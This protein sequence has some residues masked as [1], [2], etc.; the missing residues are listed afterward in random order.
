MGLS[1]AFQAPEAFL[2]QQAGEARQS[3]RTW[4]K[5]SQES[6][7]CR[8]SGLGEAGAGWPSPALVLLGCQD[9]S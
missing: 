1:T 3:G 6:E 9:R 4:R 2:N 8:G 5:G 7:G